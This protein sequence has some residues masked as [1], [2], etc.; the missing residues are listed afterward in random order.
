MILSTQQN[1]AKHVCSILLSR[2]TVSLLS[3][4]DEILMYDIKLD[5]NSDE[6]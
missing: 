3:L 2:K 4:A 1:F 6:S 5:V